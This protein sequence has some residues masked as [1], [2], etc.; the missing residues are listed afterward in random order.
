M[1]KTIIHHGRMNC[2][3]AN[4]LSI[5][6]CKL[7]IAVAL[8]HCNAATQDV[9]CTGLE[10]LAVGQEY[11]RQEKKIKT[12][13]SFVFSSLNRIFAPEK[14]QIDSIKQSWTTSAEGPDQSFW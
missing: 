8:Q 10:S 11:F 6:N 12:A 1:V 3:W 2:P 14:A 13:I 9:R 4:L 5:V 7:S